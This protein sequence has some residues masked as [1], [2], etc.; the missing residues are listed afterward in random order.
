MLVFLAAIA[1]KFCVAQELAYDA[2]YNFITKEYTLSKD[3]NVDYHYSSSLKLL[4]HQEIGR[5]HV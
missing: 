4:T 3:G 5:A 2:I 1:G